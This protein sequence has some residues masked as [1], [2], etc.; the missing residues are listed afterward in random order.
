MK[1]TVVERIALLGILSAEGN[2]ATL[3]IVRELRESLSFTE[4]EAK[5]LDVKVDGTRIQ[6]DTAKE[7]PGGEEVKIGERATDIIVAA[8]KDLDGKKKLTQQHMSLYEKFV[9]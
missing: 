4:D 1:L 5:R 2:F 9:P 8:L 7:T 3:R 6:W